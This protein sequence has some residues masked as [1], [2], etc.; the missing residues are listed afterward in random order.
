M[1]WDITFYFLSFQSTE[2]VSVVDEEE[3]G[4]DVVIAVVEESTESIS[5]AITVWL[6]HL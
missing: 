1:H 2:V 6:K 4:V 5:K 3:D